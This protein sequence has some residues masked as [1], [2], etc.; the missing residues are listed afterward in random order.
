MSFNPTVKSGTYEFVAVGKNGGNFW[1]WNGKTLEKKKGI[2]GT[3]KMADM[4]C[5]AFTSDGKCVTGS[6]LGAVYLWEN[7]SCTKTYDCHTG[8]VTAI[9]SSKGTI[10]TSGKDNQLITWDEHFVKKSTVTLST[11]A[12]AI[13]V[14]DNGKIVVGLRDGTIV[15]V[16]G[17]NVTI[18]MKSHSDGE[19]WG[20]D[21]CPKTGL[22]VTSADDNK[23]LAFDPKTRK[24]VGEGIINEKAGDKAKILGASTLS[25]YPPNQCSRAVAVN[26]V[27]GHVAAGVNNGEVH[28]RASVTDLNKSIVV[29]HDSKEWIEVMRYSPCG[30]FLAVGSHDNSVYVYD[31]NN[32]YHLLSKFHKQTAFITSLDWSTDSLNIQSIS[33][34]YELLFSEAATGK[35]LTEGATHLRDEK[36]ATWT[37][38]LGWPVQGVFPAGTEG[39]F[40]GGVHRTNNGDLLATG[41]D[42]RLV[43]LHRYPVLHGSTP[44]SYVGHSEHVV[45]VRFDEKD[46]NLYSIGGYDRTLIQWK[47]V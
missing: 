22:V 1:T 44:K 30:K 13:D 5:A 3:H 31:V 17:S 18:L 36:W 38:K 11:S 2:F 23:I 28:I 21:V 41:D 14:N 47:L 7:H 19:L 29:K 25:S 20:L 37:C 15:E 24:V 35:H 4:W 32:A 8:M 10:V 12:K 45:R 33:G 27:N 34:S 43:N 9:S 40:I 39:C 16:D 6:T 46:E 42:H 26:T